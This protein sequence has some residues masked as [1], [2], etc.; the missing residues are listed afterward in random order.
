MRIVVTGGAG[1]IGSN[2]LRLLSR[3]RPTWGLLNLDLLTYAA[4]PRTLQALERLPLPG[5]PQRGAAT[6]TAPR[7]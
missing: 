4:A 5:E 6:R 3:E 7:R 2:F 1:F